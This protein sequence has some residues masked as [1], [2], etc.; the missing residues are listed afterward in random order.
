MSP[1]QADD[2]AVE[3]LA[4]HVGEGEQRAW[5]RAP[6]RVNLMGDHTDY[7]D[8]LVLPMAVDL[9]C[10]AAV[11]PR[12]DDKVVVRSLDLQNMGVVA[13]NGSNNPEA[14]MPEWVR[15]VAGL[16]QMLAERGREPVGAEIDVASDVPLGSGLSSSAAFEVAVALALNH[17][18]GLALSPTDLARACQEAEHL[19]TGV[20]TGIMDQLVSLTAEAGHAGLIDCRT[21]TSL[22]VAV[23]D[24]LHALVVHSG[25]D[26]RLED[27]PY[28]E[29]RAA[30]EAA[31]ERLGVDSLRD[32]PPEPL[33]DDPVARH[34]VSEN[35]RAGA[36]AFAL[37]ADAR[38][39]LAETFAAS[40]ASLRDDFGCSTPAIDD[41]VTRLVDAGAIGARLTGAGWGGCV[42][43]LVDT[44]HL[45]G[46][47]AAAKD[48]DS[49]V[50]RPVAGAGP[51]K[52][53]A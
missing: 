26:R 11:R 52:A 5:F 23:P 16:V 39:T 35:A 32:L 46:T 18:G 7:H 50:C 49:W 51:L 22:P 43:A 8:G 38:H 15:L 34:V 4:A 45:A 53:P 17:V 30:G 1:P 42:V 6:G 41:L 20:P 27:T 3:R 48:F 29:R 9:D 28:A 37:A 36:C 40:H 21:L 2:R 44:E 24:D 47:Q 31:A 19:A 33:P 10:V 12:D 13:A 25:V 14:V